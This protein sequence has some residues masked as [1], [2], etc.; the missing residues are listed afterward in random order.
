[1]KTRP[2]GP[3]RWL[4]AVAALGAVVSGLAAAPPE[5][6]R[7]RVPSQRVSSYFPPK[8]TLRTLSGDQFEAL[9]ADAS[10]NARGPE[11]AD[12]R[13]PVRVEHSARWV[14]GTLVG[15]SRVTLPSTLDDPAVIACDPWSPALL[16]SDDRP[17]SVRV[18][19]SGRLILIQPPNQPAR[20]VEL[21]W[22]Q[23]AQG[24]S[25]GQAFPLR[26]PDADVAALALDLP[27]DL[28]A[29]AIAAAPSSRRE[30]A[31]PDSSRSEFVGASGWFPI[32]IRSRSAAGGLWVG[33]STRVDLSA[34]GGNWVADWRVERNA[35]SPEICRIDLD[36]GLELI[37]VTGPEVKGFRLE[38]PSGP[39]R[40]VEVALVDLDPSS[41]RA[42]SI[43]IRGEVRPPLEGPWL[44]PSARPADAGWLGG[45]TE[46]KLDPSRVATACVERSG[47]RV[48]ARPDEPGAASTWIFESDG[49]PGPVAEFRLDRPRPDASAEIQGTLRVGSFAPRVEVVAT[50]TAG[51]GRL[52]DPT[53][54][55]PRGWVV[56]RVVGADGRSDA[57]WRVEAADGIERVHFDAPSTVP[58]NDP[59]GRSLS[60]AVSATRVDPASDPWAGPMPLPRV[61]PPDGPVRV[62]GERWVARVEPGWELEPTSTR[63]LAWVDPSPT[64]APPTPANPGDEA[65]AEPDPSPL[66]S[67]QTLA[68]RWAGDDAEAT[69]VRKRTEVRPRLDERLE[70]SIV[71][72]RL[73]LAWAWTIAEAA[74]PDS[75]AFHVPIDPKASPRWRLVDRSGGPMIEPRPLDP[76][77]RSA[78]GF[79]STG[80]AS[81]IILDRL[82]PG[83]LTIRGEAEAAWSGTGPIPLI[84]FPSQVEA[85]RSVVVRVEDAARFRLDRAEGLTPVARGGAGDF[86]SSGT[87]AESSPYRAIVGDDEPGLRV[88]AA[89]LGDGS[90][91]RLDVSTV[92]DPGP[93][94]ESAV[95]TE[96]SLIS[97]LSPGSES[98]HR[99]TLRVAPGSARTLTLTMPEGTKL[100]R[101]R[102]DGQ[103]AAASD[104]GAS[105][106]VN[107]A[108][109]DPSRPTSTIILEYRTPADVAQAR[110]IAP[111]GFLPTLALPCLS[112]TWQVNAPERFSV[113]SGSTDLVATDLAR[114]ASADRWPWPWPGRS[115]VDVDREAEAPVGAAMLGDLDRTLAVASPAETTLGDWLVKLDAGRWPLVLDR[116]AMQSVGW[117]PKS[118]INVLD[119]DPRR[120][121]AASAVLRTLGLKVEP[122]GASFLVSTEG[123]ASDSD[124]AGSS[125]ALFEAAIL[126]SDRTDRF[127]SPARWRG[128][129]TPRAWLASETPDR[130]MVAFGWQSHRFAASS[131]PGASSAILLDDARAQARRQG[132]VV[133]GLAVFLAF[134]LVSRRSKRRRRG[135]IAPALVL[136][137]AWSASARFDPSEPIIAVI[138]YDDLADLDGK[139]DRVILRQ[140]DHDRLVQLAR[141][142]RPRPSWAALIAATHH[143]AR[144]ADRAVLVE[145]RYTLEVVGPVASSWTFPVGPAFDLAATIDGRPSPLVISPDGRSATLGAI[146]P[147]RPLVVFRRSVPWVGSGRGG[148]GGSIRVPVDRSAFALVEV[149]RGE[150]SSQVELPDLAG[151]VRGTPDGLVGELGPRDRIDVRWGSNPPGPG[152]P[153]LDATIRWD[154]HP[155]GDRVIARLSVGGKTPIGAVRLA[156]G[157]GLAVVGQTIPGLVGTA[158]TGTSGRPEWVAHVDPPLGPG[159]SFEVT[160]WRP[161]TAP[162]P[163]RTFPSLTLVGGELTGVVGF[164][165]P[166]G[167]SGRLVGA[168][169]ADLPTELDFV[170]RWGPMTTDG[171]SLAGS[172]RW[173]GS[174]AIVARV[175]PEPVKLGVRDQVAV[176][177]IAGGLRFAADSV[178]TARLAPSWDAEAAFDGP[179]RLARV[180]ANGLS[181]WTQPRPDRVRLAFDGS[182]PARERAIRLEGTVDGPRPSADGDGDGGEPAS[183]PVPWPR[184]AGADPDGE[185]ANAKLVV[186][187]EGEFRVAAG[188]QSLLEDPN[189]PPSTSSKAPTRTRK[190]YSAR[191]LDPGSRVEWTTPRARVNVSVR[192][193]LRLDPTHVTWTADVVCEVSGGSARTLYWK[194]PTAWAIGAALADTDGAEPR[195]EAETRGE[196]TFWTITLD[197]PVWNRRTLTIRSARPL[198]P[199][200]AV[201]YPEVAPLSMPGRGEVARYDLAVT[202]LSGVPLTLEAASGVTSLATSGD[203]SSPTRVPGGALSRAFR[204]SGN[205]WSLRLRLDPATAVE[206]P[207]RLGRFDDSGRPARV[208][209]VDFEVA[210]DRDTAQGRA[211]VRLR[212]GSP[213]LPVFLPRRARLIGAAVE[214]RAT[215]PVEPGAGGGPRW[216]IPLGDRDARRVVFGWT[217]PAPTSGQVPSAPLPQFDQPSVPTS[218]RV[219][220]PAAGIGW[221]IGGGGTWERL[222]PLQ[223]SLARFERLGDEVREAT[224]RVNREPT[225]ARSVAILDPL[226]EMALNLRA[227]RRSLQVADPN[228][229]PNLGQ[230]LAIQDRVDALILEAGLGSLLEETKERVGLVPPGPEPGRN[231]GFE[232]A[233]DVYRIRPIGQPYHFRGLTSPDP[234]QPPAI[235]E[236]SSHG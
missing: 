73:R 224:E 157:P 49:R 102:R 195:V 181:S 168:S 99:L 128:E 169:S 95:V 185:V 134:A 13:R 112:F 167:W 63:G 68:W 179:V 2:H 191:R 164:R 121:L 188:G 210:V 51:L 48:A 96:A 189:Q 21:R 141:P 131:W 11:P 42:A 39:G 37:D 82:P 106:R 25:L 72:G 9:V 162:G 114:P 107:L 203:R 232:E 109:T 74:R 190:T 124:R 192:S 100:D 34:S 90:P 1:M 16:D 14:D 33:G 122:I 166:V 119:P 125:E 142:T 31:F 71:G 97:R 227:A 225:S 22:R 155:A 77:E 139:P 212:P 133:I 70:A 159:T 171:L 186:E 202:Q 67:G 234:T 7:V 40:R 84:Q 79:P 101:V 158:M 152:R 83:T 117:G 5:V 129:P 160:L 120:P 213:F 140:E 55:L 226:V 228:N 221:T 236:I 201:D 35:L 80:T 30:S 104:H 24:D 217:Q 46:V 146:P 130:G 148:G 8:T 108:L 136:M 53:L 180:E 18:D 41:P 43:T 172:S 204:V 196:S 29:S 69:V 215:T 138:P 218:V 178:L 19:R 182:K 206:P 45:R 216:L 44:V 75:L 10:A 26:L 173:D 214:G 231:V 229:R 85:R 87:E 98:R 38:P 165:E 64:A 60:L 89:W 78:R 52:F 59:S 235:Q 207:L 12:A 144:P 54:D 20:V 47:R 57:T 62:A 28:L 153:E 36:D 113:R 103:A 126:G 197:R 93:G 118:R 132:L 175:A 91:G 149:D 198:V 88:A 163:I 61:R 65:T 194:L 110:P 115:G 143:V 66:A 184:W 116:L 145:S 32:M 223:A 105:I 187:G 17:G 174:R 86:R 27:A 176:E 154:A 94:E 127:Q 199:G 135:L 156:L 56:D 147:G 50:W 92:L 150:G 222:T 205:P 15:R 4:G 23:A 219:T 81:E 183:A 208:E 193:D 58:G 211:E 161:A 170:R 209:Q 137:A 233:P 6:V 123:A 220:S 76:A 200:A 151:T 230:W 111:S 3:G 177:V